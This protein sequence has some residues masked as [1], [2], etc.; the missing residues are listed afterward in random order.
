MPKKDQIWFSCSRHDDWWELYFYPMCF[1]ECLP[2]L[3]DAIEG[4]QVVLL[5]FEGTRQLR[6]LGISGL[7]RCSKRELPAVCT[8]AKSQLSKFENIEQWDLDWADFK[9]R[10]SADLLSRIDIRVFDNTLSE[11]IN[12]FSEVGSSVLFSSHDNESAYMCV[13]NYDVAL[14]FLQYLLTSFLSE[15]AQGQDSMRLPDA[16]FT[17]LLDRSP[18]ELIIDRRDVIIA[19]GQVSF[20]CWQ[21]SFA[22]RIRAFDVNVSDEQ[23]SFS[24]WEERPRPEYI[25]EL[26]SGCSMRGCLLFLAVLI[27]VV[28]IFV[29]CRTVS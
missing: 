3:D 11:Y 9:K 14:K 25:R 27:L 10:P 8:F 7:E 17:R 28:V 16:L 4:E 15:R 1:A 29:I 13:R 12:L 6:K 2:L 18:D 5:E 23:I 19:E 21:A 26:I 22:E 24:D 20:T